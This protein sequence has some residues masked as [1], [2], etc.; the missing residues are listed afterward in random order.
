MNYVENQTDRQG[1]A[2]PK[3]SLPVNSLRETPYQ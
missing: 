1:E 2:T 3:G